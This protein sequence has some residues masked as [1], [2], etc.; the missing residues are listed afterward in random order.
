MCLLLLTRNTIH[1]VVILIKHVKFYMYY[2]GKIM[3]YLVYILKNTNYKTL[4]LQ[5]NNN[6]SKGEQFH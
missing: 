6:L 1:K 3:S 4:I 2:N 5:I